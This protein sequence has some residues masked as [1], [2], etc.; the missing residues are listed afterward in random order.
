MYYDSLD[1]FIDL[2]D[3]VCRNRIVGAGFVL[4]SVGIFL[5]NTR[6]GI[7]IWVD[8]T[9][10]MGISER[11]YDAPLYAWMLQPILALFE[12]NTGAKLLGLVIVAANSGLIW[13]LLIRAT[14]RSRHA[15]LGTLLIIL[16]PQF[17]TLHA[18][19]MSEPT[20]LFFTL[21]T[22]LAFLR[23]LENDSRSWLVACA[24]ALA[25]ATLARFVAP[26]L[27]AA[28]AICILVNPRHDIG[29]RIGHA[30]LL[31]VVS[32]S[33]F[34]SW[35]FYS[36]LTTGRSIGRDLWFY[37]N[38]GTREWL[39]SLEA[40]TAWLLPDAIP[41]AVRV[42]TFASFAVAITALT[43]V[44]TSQALR[45]AHAVRV[46]DD[47]LP[48]TLGLFFLLYLAFVVL[49]TS[50]E[51]NLSLNSRYAF[52]IYI[53]TILMTT[54]VL[55]RTP[56]VTGTVKLLRYGL[57]VLLVLVAIGHVARTTARSQEAS[58]M[59]VG[60]ASL[61]WRNSPTIS[62]IRALPTDSLLYSNGADVIAYIL[63][64]P[65]SFIPE[66]VQLRTGRENPQNPLDLQLERMRANTGQGLSH[67]VIFD[68]VDWRFYLLDEA[69]LVQRLS[70]ELIANETDG[71][72][73]AISRRRK[74]N[75]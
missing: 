34:L 24:I 69:E 50:L 60:Y 18:S 36:H 15:A 41:F 43:F 48:A 73:Y 66:R 5:V 38:M 64:R 4:L 57:V 12:S 53:T 67:V 13:Y 26:P 63:G 72:I 30:A 35:L 65:A 10:Y 37:G 25:L 40:L 52:P 39:A 8:S 22:L 1:E 21:L 55:A 32:A 19:A 58:R 61:A 75:E 44:H 29:R 23:Y 2:E 71:R 51:A 17:V 56:H 27:G 74:S 11:P 42:I 62:A 46:V 7:G 9:R 68:K 16:S 28:L 31:A 45:R 70:L 33:I 14:N 3:R 59:G 54:I 47:L 49:S 20:F 6:Q